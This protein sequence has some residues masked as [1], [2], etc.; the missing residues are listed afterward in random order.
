MADPVV[1]AADTGGP[2]GAGYPSFDRL[3]IESMLLAAI[4]CTE[5]PYLFSLMLAGLWWLI[6]GDMA[7]SRP[8]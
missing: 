3:T 4:A 5:D 1:L 2:S 7:K 6:G 8:P